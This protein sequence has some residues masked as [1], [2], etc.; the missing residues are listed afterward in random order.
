MLAGFTS[1]DKTDLDVIGS[2]SGGV[3][4]LKAALTADDIC[5]GLLREKFV[6]D[7]SGGG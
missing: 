3:D 2:G 1:L 7:D 4:E 6:F 5:Y